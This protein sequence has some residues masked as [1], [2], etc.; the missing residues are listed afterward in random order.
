MAWSLFFI[1]LLYLT[2]PALAV[3]VK[4]EV[5]QRPGGQQLRRAA[6]LDRAVGARS[7]P[8]LISV[9]DVNGDGILQF[10]EIRLGADIIVLATPEIGGLPYVVSGPGGGRRPGGGAVHR[11]RPAADHQQRAGAR[12]LLP[13]DRPPR[14][15]RSSA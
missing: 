7:T 2:A 3:L 4:F 14:H 10:G 9:T 1:V 15:A 5:M 6:G 11:R 8:S 13:R 12:P